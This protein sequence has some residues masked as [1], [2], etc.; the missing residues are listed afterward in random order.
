MRSSIFF[1]YWHILQRA[2]IPG[3]NLQG[4]FSSIFQTLCR[5]PSPYGGSHMAGFSTGCWG[6]TSATIW[7]SSQVGDDPS[8]LP[9]PPFPP[10]ASPSSFLLVREVHSLRV[11]P[12]RDPSSPPSVL[13]SFSPSEM[14]QQPIRGQGSLFKV[15]CGL[16]I[17]Y[18]WGAYFGIWV[19][20]ERWQ[21]SGA[22]SCIFWRGRTG[23]SKRLWGGR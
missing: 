8:D 3:W 16:F 13:F 2:T 11:P 7:V 12:A 15:T 21:R 1:L 20:L 10:T 17:S 18:Y 9:L 6:P 4:L 22:K 5:V 23:S 19:L 14:K